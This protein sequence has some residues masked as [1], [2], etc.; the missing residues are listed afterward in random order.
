MTAV[1]GLHPAD[2][3]RQTEAALQ[4][5]LQEA[6]SRADLQVWSD[7]VWPAVQEFVA[8]GKRLRPVLMVMA[9]EGYAGGVA[10]GVWRCAAAVEMFHT[11]ALVHDD[12]V[13]GSTQ[14][15]SRP[16]MTT[17][18]RA[19]VSDR[20]RPDRIADELAMLVGDA[21][22]SLAVN[23]FMGCALPAGRVGEAMRLLSGAGVCT[24]MGAVSELLLRT[25]GVVPTEA[26]LLDLYDRKTGVYS[27]ACPLQ[28]G[29]TLGGAADEEMPVLSEFGRQ[30]GR[31]FQIHD[32]LGD[33]GAFLAN[34]FPSLQPCEMRLMLPVAYALDRAEATDREWLDRATRAES[35]SREDRDRAR[36]LLDMARACVDARNTMQA[37]LGDAGT[38]AQGLSMS[39]RVREMIV[40]FCRSLVE[41]RG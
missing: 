26:E 41:E 6:R 39:P 12:I 34:G 18:L 2:Y 25:D 13:D 15:R 30:M 3:A 36:R 21:L 10:R 38:T 29:A 28:I 33:L 14:R 7:A 35:M 22:Y 4:E 17:R 31:A 11:F 8:R 9:C 20:A 23:A 5:V 24:G 19:L 40:C 37:C 1:R 27:F 16:S 32:D